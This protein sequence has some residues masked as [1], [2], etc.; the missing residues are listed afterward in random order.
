MLFLLVLG[1][2]SVSA[3]VRIGGDEIPNEAT[4][5][6]LNADDATDTGTKG[7]ALPR[8]SL[9]SHDDDLGYSGLLEGLL[10]YNTNASMT[11]GD[12]VGVYYWD[13]NEWVK[14]AGIIADNSITSAKIADGTIVTADL[15]SASV[16]REKTNMV[17]T[18]FGYTSEPAGTIF[19]ISYPT[20]CNRNNAIVMNNGGGW[21]I[22][23]LYD[24][25][26]QLW[27]VGGD[28]GNP[29]YLRF[30]CF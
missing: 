18:N 7:L 25:V 4:I 13:G 5:L 9:V 10:V 11:G 3:Q 27:T 17:V 6:D 21:V 1:A 28:S 30:Y 8:V 2:A 14:P 26:V 19:D 16:T 29:G 23:K 20:G 24:T 22:A 12:G 15:A